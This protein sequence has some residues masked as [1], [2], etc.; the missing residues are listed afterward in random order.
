MRRRKPSFKQ[1]MVARTIPHRQES[2]R[3]SKQ[4]WRNGPGDALGHIIEAS[5]RTALSSPFGLG[6]YN[7]HRAIVRVDTRNETITH[8]Q[9]LHCHDTLLR[10]SLFSLCQHSA[11]TR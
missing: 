4:I 8:L 5:M 1:T 6:S 11:M 3:A 9:G 10:V 7:Y 2:Q